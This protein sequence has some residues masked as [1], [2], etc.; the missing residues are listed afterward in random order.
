[1]AGWLLVAALVSTGL[2]GPGARGA[3]VVATAAPGASRQAVI[4]EFYDRYV[5][6]EL[7]P[8]GW[9]GSEAGC[10]AGTTSPA[11]EAATLDQINYFRSFYGLA[12]VS[13][14]PALS[15][16][17]Q[18]AALMMD[19]NNALSHVPPAG[20]ACY[21]AAGAEAASRSNLSSVGGAEAI[22]SY[23]R[24]NGSTNTSAGHRRWVLNPSNAVMGSGSTPDA[25]ALWV[26][27]DA[28][29]PGPSPEWLPFPPAGWFP[30][31]LEPW[32]RWS[33]SAKDRLT[34]LSAASVAMTGPAGPVAVTVHPAEVGFGPNTIVWDAGVLADPTPGADVTYTVSVSGAVRDG[35]VLPTYTYAVTLVA[36][37]RSSSVVAAPVVTGTPVDGATL[38]AVAPVFSP[39]PDRL[40]YAW[41]RNGTPMGGFKASQ[42]T[43]EVRK[44]DIGSVI[45]VRVTASSP[46]RYL[47]P[48]SVDSAATSPVLAEPVVAP[49]QGGFTLRKK[50]R[51]EGTARVGSRLRIVGGVVTPTARARAVKWYRGTKLVKSGSG[52]TYRL[53]AKDKGK[54]IR[55]KVT[56]SSPRMVPLT[57]W[58]PRSA[59][60]R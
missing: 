33:L 8:L 57:T 37:D 22:T 16:K 11:A 56:F 43:Y 34:D 26:I 13:F 17:A 21:S 14:D 46:T 28:S 7:V 41:L 1:M 53:T 55:A 23:M 51:L 27:P 30:E 24:D 5:V 49:A 2:S 12:A 31:P 29:T 54:R 25:N 36:P 32:G 18:Q 40:D 6:N 38:T 44:A 58:T 4:D 10:A 45:S 47:L 35:A 59:K 42:P 3:F 52:T 20:W 15:A 9:T 60:V 19:A 48:T 39:A 50:P